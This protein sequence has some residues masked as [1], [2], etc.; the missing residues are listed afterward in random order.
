MATNE[1]ITD[2]QLHCHE[3]MI[4]KTN[5]SH[6]WGTTTKLWHEITILRGFG[7]W[8]Q[9]SN[10]A[11]MSGM[12]YILVWNNNLKVISPTGVVISYI[13]SIAFIVF[14]GVRS[15]DMNY[16][17]VTR[18]YGPQGLCMCST[19]PRHVGAIDRALKCSTLEW[20]ES[21]FRFFASPY[22]SMQ[23]INNSKQQPPPMNN[24]HNL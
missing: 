24:Y 11:K 20:H 2:T 9:S 16:N 6:I 17:L 10:L 19:H 5:K 1:N 22:W 12:T 23:A 7:G 13:G 14:C 3:S 8:C 21:N 15:K 18:A 4:L